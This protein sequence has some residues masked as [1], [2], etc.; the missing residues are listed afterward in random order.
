MTTKKQ[1]SELE[2]AVGEWVFEGLANSW[3]TTEILDRTVQDWKKVVGLPSTLRGFKDLAEWQGQVLELVGLGLGWE[4]AEKQRVRS[5]G[6]VMSAFSGA[7]P[8]S[9]MSLFG[10]SVAEDVLED[11]FV[12]REELM[13]NAFSAGSLA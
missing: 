7:G 5:A 12:G 6:I 4:V 11:R 9:I 10:V 3:T 1:Q 13:R 8:D 2:A